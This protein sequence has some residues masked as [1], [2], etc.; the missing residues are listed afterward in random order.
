L[1]SCVCPVCGSNNNCL[2][3]TN[4][5]LPLFNCN[6]CDFF[7]CNPLPDIDSDSA[8]SNAVFTPDFFTFNAINSN[9]ARKHLFDGVAQQRHE[10]FSNRL[11]RKKYKLLDIGCGNAGTAEKYTELG[12]EYLG[13]DIDGRMIESAQDRG[14]NVR[15]CDLFELELDQYFDVIMFSQVLEHIIN[16]RLFIERIS[17]ILSQDGIVVC[18]VPNHNS[19]AGLLSKSNIRI[20]S[21]DNSRFGGIHLSHHAMSYNQKSIKYLFQQYFERVDVFTANP[22]HIIWGQ[23]WSPN[24]KHRLYYTIADIFKNQALLLAISTL[25]K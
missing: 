21:A 17:S 18:D 12:V 10:Y 8:N 20:F 24:L 14:V 1:C 15:K 22:D 7:F 16:P 2:V 25:K 6:K 3:R 5:S 4:I 23:A 11:N 9:S 13:I 19:L